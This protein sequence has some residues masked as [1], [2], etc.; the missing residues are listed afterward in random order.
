MTH[1]PPPFEVR[2]PRAALRNLNI[3]IYG[4]PGSG[5]TVLA[6]SAGLHKQMQPVLVLDAEGGSLSIASTLGKEVEKTIAI[7]DTSDF[8]GAVRST[9]VYLA[10]RQHPYRT[11]V[12]D[13]G[14]EL[15]KLCL[16][17]VV[18]E[19]KKM[20]PDHDSDIAD[21]H[22]WLKATE[23]V[24]KALRYYRDLPMHFVMTAL[25]QNVKNE[26]TGAVTIVPS[27][28]GKLAEEVP[29]YFDIVGYLTTQPAKDGGVERVLRVQPVGNPAGNYVAKDR[30]NCLGDAMVSPTL[31]GI[32]DAANAKV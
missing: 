30:T 18:R 5:K 20:K 19:V 3:L 16:A 10:K 24:R 29:G 28:P 2:S 11:V 23:Q 27:L 9:Y 6:G 31:G 7:R 32:L 25:A 22:D 13:S 17:D 12:W 4:Q 1:T 15:Q 26:L 14:T 8:V 21:L